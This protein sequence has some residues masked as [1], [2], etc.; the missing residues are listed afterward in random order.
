[1]DTLETEVRKMSDFP[2]YA[3]HYQ[4]STPRMSE[5]LYYGW[6]TW[7]NALPWWGREGQSILQCPTCPQ[8]GQGP[9]S[10]KGM[11]SSLL[12]SWYYHNGGRVAC[13]LMFFGR[14]LK[15]TPRRWHFYLS[16]GSL[17]LNILRGIFAEL[18]SCGPSPSLLSIPDFKQ[19]FFF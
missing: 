11:D 6:G 18:S 16:Q 4:P 5:R 2:W 15:P 13:I 14:D 8:F 12:S 1:M 17:S 19:I 10:R 3:W 9:G 7:E